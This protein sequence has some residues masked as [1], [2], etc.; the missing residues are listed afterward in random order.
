MARL[1]KVAAALA[2]AAALTGGAAVAQP[3]T[4]YVVRGQVHAANST[5]LAGYTVRLMKKNMAREIALGQAITDG[6]GRYQIGYSSSQVDRRGGGADVIVRVFAPGGGA[7]ALAQSKLIYNVTPA[8]TVNLTVN[9][10][11][12]ARRKKL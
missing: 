6:S 12:A 2:I 11:P 9:R 5:P 3:A 4:N 10:A 8:M 1:V 7:A